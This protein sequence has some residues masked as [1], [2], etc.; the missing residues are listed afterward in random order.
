MLLEGDSLDP[1][2]YRGLLGN[3]L[4]PRDISC[5]FTLSDESTMVRTAGLE[6]ALAYAKQILSLLCLPIP[7]RPHVMG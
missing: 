3:P 1:D 5:D 6:P 4:P 7:P 2:G